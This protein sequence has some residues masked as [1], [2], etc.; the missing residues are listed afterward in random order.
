MPL[1]KAKARATVLNNSFAAETYIKHSFKKPK[2]IDRLAM[3][4]YLF[5]NKS[6]N[7]VTIGG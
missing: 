1:C 6:G 2:Q 4:N 5:I 3:A 7:Q